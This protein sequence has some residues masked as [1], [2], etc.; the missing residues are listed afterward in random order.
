MKIGEGLLIIQMSK[1]V[2][3]FS[4]LIIPHLNNPIFNAKC[5]AKVFADIMMMDL[6][7]QVVNI[8]TIEYCLPIPGFRYM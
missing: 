2:I 5:I 3:E 6:D 8:P 7:N 4:I 1:L